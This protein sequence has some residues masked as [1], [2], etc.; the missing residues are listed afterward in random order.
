VFNFKIILPFI[1]RFAERLSSSRLHNLQTVCIYL[2]HHTM[3]VKI[4]N[5]DI[6]STKV[7]WEIHC[8]ISTLC[9]V[10]RGPSQWKEKFL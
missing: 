10:Q 2:P 5:I 1:P 6:V 8:V 4:G 9:G 7:K 3:P